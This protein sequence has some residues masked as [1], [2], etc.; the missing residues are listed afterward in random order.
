M[1]IGAACAR[2][3]A[4]AK[5]M[6][7]FIK[8]VT[9]YAVGILPVEINLGDKFGFDY[10]SDY[11]DYNG[12]DAFEAGEELTRRRHD[13]E[14][15]RMIQSP[16]PGLAL[17]CTLQYTCELD[18][19]TGRSHSTMPEKFL[20]YIFS[21][22]KAVFRKQEGVTYGGLGTCREM[23]PCPWD[24]QSLVGLPIPGSEGT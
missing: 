18:R 21:N 6:D 8:L 19:W 13:D 9:L 24:V 15:P 22:D 10:Q 3:G 17:D 20:A 14:K 1:P 5:Y 11:E 23:Y 7:V 2:R 12:A 16:L 4:L